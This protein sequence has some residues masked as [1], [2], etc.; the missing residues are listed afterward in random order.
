MHRAAGHS[1]S[2]VR[3]SH[4]GRCGGVGFRCEGGRVGGGEGERPSSRDSLWRGRPPSHP[5]RRQRLPVSGQAAVPVL[6]HRSGRRRGAAA[7]GA[8]GRRRGR[9]HGPGHGA[10]LLAVP[11]GAGGAAAVS[12]LHVG[13]PLPWTTLRGA[14]GAAAALYDTAGHSRGCSRG[15]G[16]GAPARLLPWTMDYAAGCRLGSAL[17]DA[18]GQ[19]VGRCRG[20]Y[21]RLTAEPRP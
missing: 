14:G 20:R 7:D 4:C 16:H 2:F 19:P 3:L 1:P 5:A 15:G 17:V 18:T 21:R 12:T 13:G 11:R 8:A 10:L 6:G 9:C